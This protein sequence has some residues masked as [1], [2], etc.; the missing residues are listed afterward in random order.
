MR[1]IAFP[2]APNLPMFAALDFGWFADR[3]LDVSL[4]LT[5]SSVS[6]A[7]RVGAGEFDLAFTA[8][9]NVLAY[10]RGT[11]LDPGYVTVMGATQLEVSLVVEPD[12]TTHADLAGRT[13][14]LDALGTGFAFILYEMLERAGV[15]ISDCIIEPI[16]STPHRWH[17]VRSGTHAATLTIEPFTSLATNAGFRVLDTSTRLFDHYQG[18][19]VT[20]RRNVLETRPDEVTRFL[21]GYLDGL[22]WV[23]TPGRRQDVMELLLRHMEVNP[24]AMDAVLESV[25]SPRTGLM[26]DG[27][28]TREGMETVRAL[29]QHH[30]EQPPPDLDD[31]VD[32]TLWRHALEERPAR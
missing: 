3:G 20:T 23:L 16:G 29:R 2:G 31:V 13:L 5:T 28:P 15:D 27:E 22:D 21:H 26:P 10:H 14:A 8:F 32:L 25:L 7:E 18:G 19:V 11:A 12:V 30:G 24:A 4:E 1:V 17:A 9:D 6:Q